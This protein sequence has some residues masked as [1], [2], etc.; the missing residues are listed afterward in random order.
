MGDILL[1]QIIPLKAKERTITGKAVSGLRRAGQVPGVVYGRGVQKNVVVDRVA[2]S[3]AYA[4]AG[5]SSLVDL[6]LED[7]G[8]PTKVLI[9]DVA[10][11]PVRG[12][13]I[14]V[15]FYAVSMTE[16]LRTQIPLAPVGESPAVKEQGGVLVKSLGSIEVECLPADLVHEISVP[17]AAL[18]SFGDVIRVKDLALPSGIVFLVDANTVVATVSAPRSEEELKALEGAVETDVSKV[19]VMKKEKKDDEEAAPGEAPAGAEKGAPAKGA[20]QKGASK[21][22]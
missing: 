2:L 10:V 22:E 4:R 20:A 21:K 3:K 16:K 7:G 14:H 1:M 9:Q 18:K 11:D 17:L 8:Q 12:A 5:E 19:E 13:P 6:A 15:D